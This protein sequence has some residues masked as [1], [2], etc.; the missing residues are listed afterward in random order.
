MNN[1][2]VSAPQAATNH[3]GTFASHARMGIHPARPEIGGG[4]SSNPW[5]I[6]WSSAPPTAIAAPIAAGEGTDAPTARAASITAAS[7]GTITAPARRSTRK[8]HAVTTA[9]SAKGNAQRHPSP[10][11]WPSASISPNITTG[12]QSMWPTRLPVRVWKS[13][14]IS[15]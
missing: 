3:T 12:V 6:V 7:R 9:E 8:P 14:Y 13:S 15:A 5:L 4:T 11:A 10:G 1:P 2:T